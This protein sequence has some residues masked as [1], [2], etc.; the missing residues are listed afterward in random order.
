MLTIYSEEHR[1]QNGQWEL[2]DGQL[3]PPVEKPERADRIVAAM[4]D[5]SSTEMM[6]PEAVHDRWLTHVHTPD[7]VEFLRGAWDEWVTAHG[8]WDAL[9]LNWVGR[10]MRPVPPVSIDGKLGYYSFDA[11]TPVTSGTWR[12]ITASADVALTGARKVA[13]GADKVFSLC[14]PPGHHASADCYGGYCFLNNAALAATFLRNPG[15]E[16]SAIVNVDYHHGN[17]TQSIF[18]Q[19]SDV[20]FVSIHADPRQEFPFFLGHG[21]ETGTGAGEGYNLN[22]PLPWGTGWDDGYARALETACRRVDS[23]DPD[24]V[25]VSLGT[26]THK[27]DPISQFRLETSHFGD[28]GKRLRQLARPTLIVM[29]G[30]YAID[31]LGANVAGMIRGFE[32]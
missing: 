1:F 15:Y 4:R 27:D 21:E 25:I 9:P 10:V 29:E 8:E 20:L 16:K 19:R 3:Q 23:Y 32:G 11:G 14:R 30:G 2:I 6:A 13:L 31:A 5:V 24:V 28:I 18:Y 17:G 22:L 26:D 7:Y 12:A